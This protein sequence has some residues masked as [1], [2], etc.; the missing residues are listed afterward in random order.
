MKVLSTLMLSLYTFASTSASVIDCSAGKSLFSVTSMSFSPDPAVSGQNSTL[1]LSMNVP[2]QINDGT[3]TYKITF[4]FVPVSTNSEKLCD[5]VPCPIM[6]GPLSIVSS[7]DFSG[8]P[9]GTIK[10]DI[11]W[12]DMNSRN[13]LCVSISTK[14][15]NDAKQLSVYSTKP[16]L[17]YPMCSIHQNITY[18]RLAK[19]LKKNPIQIEVKNRTSRNLRGLN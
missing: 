14:T 11:K 5:I 17:P 4:N 6:P 3:A 8:V 15:G 9:S 13:L 10:A 19:R 7:Y 2:E 1:N 18:Q 16:F 12:V